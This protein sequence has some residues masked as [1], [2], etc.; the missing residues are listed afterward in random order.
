MYQKMLVK[1]LPIRTGLTLAMLFVAL[2]AMPTLVAHAGDII[3]NSIADNTITDGNCTLREAIT[4]AN[5][6]AATYTDCA[7][8]GGHDTL[9]ITANGA[10]ILSSALPQ[11]SDDATI[12][13]PGAS[14]LSISGDRTWR[15]FY[16]NS[17]TAVTITGMTIRD[18][19]S[20]GVGSNG[21]GI[22]SAGDLRL[23]QTN[24]LSNSAAS[25]GGGVYVAQGTAALTG[26]HVLGNST[27][28]FG[29]GVYISSG[30]AAL[31]ASGGEI[32]RNSAAN[33]GGGVYVYLGTATLTGTH[34][35]GNSTATSGG[36]M[37]VYQGTA[38]LTGTHVLS[39]S[40]QGGGGG[41]YVYWGTATLT[42]SGGEISRNSA[43][44]TG[45]GVYIYRGTAMLTGTHVLSNSAQADG[46]G[47]YL[48]S[49]GAI[50]ATHGCVVNNSDTSADNATGGSGTLVA[51]DN[52]WGV[53][54]G[55]GGVG[56]GSGDSISADVDYSNFKTA[57]PAGCPTLPP[58]LTL[59][60][61]VDDNVPRPGQ[62]ITYTIAVTHTKGI[63][64]T[65]VLISDTLPGDLTF[66][67]PMTLDPPGAGTTGTPPTLVSGL[68]I[69]PWERVTV[70]FPVMVNRGLMAGTVITNTVAVTSTEAMMP[71]TGAVRLTISV[72]E[73]L[74][75]LPFVLK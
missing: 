23:S 63:A 48:D 60:K 50:A 6:D 5:N 74:V 72:T 59:S 26:T 18:G 42:A 31:A 2:L 33:T 53:A 71:L 52:W 36:G 64:A 70:T 65:N 15:V 22:Y 37:Y 38:T 29:G 28:Q 45:G 10:I 4:N 9:T 46:G 16:I 58:A 44:N 39:N 32:S 1:R 11:L 55:P 40:A 19:Y 66:A 47:L 75:Y 61:W 14:S 30:T 35:L 54:N 51:T 7:A 73:H 24:V 57:P 68:T 27:S 25:F 43:A 41:V 62:R 12:T 67:G 13:G 8:G 34:V 69:T 17:G 21:G 56:P 49:S 3:V 20:G